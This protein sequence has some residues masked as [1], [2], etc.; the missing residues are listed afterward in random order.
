MAQYLQ[1]SG[2][3]KIEVS[4]GDVYSITAKGIEMV[5]DTLAPR[6]WGSI[7]YG[8]T[9]EQQRESASP[10]VTPD[11]F[12]NAAP[13]GEAPVEIQESLQ[14][15]KKDHPQPNKVA[16][17]MMQFGKTQAHNKI[18]EA[19]RHGLKS[20]GIEGVRADD[21]RYHDDVFYNVLTYMHGCGM[22]MAVFERIKANAPNPNVALEVGY[23][24]ALRKPVCLLKDETLDA[25]QADLVGKLYDDF[26]PQDPAGTIPTVVQ[27]WLADKDLPDP[28]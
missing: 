8:T 6:T 5:E 28:S 25:L 21:K 2:L 4:E 26:D 7:L 27:T 19:V 22:G 11:E 16:F 23:L 18:A 12:S 20:R 10:R 17:I 14:R 3:I 15:F 13:L 24:F 1:E 9:S